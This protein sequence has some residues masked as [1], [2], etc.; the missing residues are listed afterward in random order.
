MVINRQYSDLSQFSKNDAVTRKNNFEKK[1]EEDTKLN[2]DDIPLINSLQSQKFKNPFST[3]SLLSSKNNKKRKKSEKRNKNKN[4]N[5][6][7]NC[8]LKLDNKNNEGSKSQKPR[9]SFLIMKNNEIWNSFE[10]HPSNNTKKSKGKFDFIKKNSTKSNLDDS[11]DNFNFQEILEKNIKENLNKHF[12]K[13]NKYSSFDVVKNF[14]NY[15]PNN[16]IENIVK[17]LYPKEADEP[18]SINI[19]RTKTLKQR[20]KKNSFS[21]SHVSIFS[22]LGNLLTFKKKDGY[23]IKPNINLFRKN[24]TRD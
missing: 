18:I 11:V 6:H 7:K 3:I 14:K 22:K 12:Q 9:H 17:N 8:L 2:K 5:T 16:N 19:F 24:N 20:R 13:E 21:S 23:T 4:T 1:K 10:I 15:F